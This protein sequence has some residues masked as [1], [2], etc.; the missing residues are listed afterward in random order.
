[1]R[2][3]GRLRGDVAGRA[4]VG[5]RTAPGGLVQGLISGAAGAGTGWADGRTQ[6]TTAQEPKASEIGP[7]G[8]DFPGA[9]RPRDCVP[10]TSRR[11]IQRD[12]RET[13]CRFA[14]PPATDDDEAD[15]APQSDRQQGERPVPQD[16]PDDRTGC[17]N[18]GAELMCRG[19]NAPIKHRGIVP[20][21][22]A[23]GSPRGE[24]GWTRSRSP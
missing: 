17:R 21:L 10:A 14:P 24:P 8:A 9:G 6:D 11:G 1:M 16:F 20:R 12:T 19:P 13:A 5:R 7:R 3:I 22:A 2:R 23:L 15:E 4:A 18:P